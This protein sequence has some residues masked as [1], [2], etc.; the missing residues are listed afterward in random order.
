ML[1]IGSGRKG[2]LGTAAIH[3]TGNKKT[4]GYQDAA[5]PLRQL[6][7]SHGQFCCIQKRRKKDLQYP[8]K[9]A[10]RGKKPLSL[11]AQIIPPPSSSSRQFE[12]LWK[13]SGSYLFLKNFF[14]KKSSVQDEP[15]QEKLKLSL[16]FCLLLHKQE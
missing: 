6:G 1:P 12:S 16:A 13:S 5:A 3:K 2:F 11:Q 15:L 9:L 10:K 4:L 7:C 8:Q 14:L